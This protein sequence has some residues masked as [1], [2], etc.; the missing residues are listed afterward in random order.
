[1]NVCGALGFVID[2]QEKVTPI[3][4][5]ARPATCGAQLVDTLQRLLLNRPLEQLRTQTQTLTVVERLTDQSSRCARGRLD[6]LLERGCIEDAAELPLDSLFCEWAYLI[7][8]DRHRFE[9]YRGFQRRPH[10]RGRWSTQSPRIA[11]S[12]GRYWPVR[13][14]RRWPL[15]AL[16]SPTELA[17]RR[18]W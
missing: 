12:G 10:R 6:V 11:H 7:D 16:P 17:L 13:L 14:V 9:I 3:Y 2:G 4:G 8:L 1:M 18:R 5:D 15:R